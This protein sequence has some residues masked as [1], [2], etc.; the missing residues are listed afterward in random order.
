MEP[1]ALVDHRFGTGM[2]SFSRFVRITTAAFF[3]SLLVGLMV[4]A[5]VSSSLFGLSRNVRQLRITA[6]TCGEVNNYC[7]PADTPELSKA[8]DRQR[9]LGLGCEI[10]PVLTDSI[11]FQRSDDMS[12]HVLT[13]DQA[14]VASGRK[15]GWVQRY[16][17]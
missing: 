1:G 12:V 11:L 2:V 9:E 8:I 4:I 15:L 14:L 7:A 3:G 10:E 16:C 13:L 5:L 6:E 17:R